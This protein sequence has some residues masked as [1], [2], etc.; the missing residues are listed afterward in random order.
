MNFAI[1]RQDNAELL[2]YLWKIIDLPFIYL[3]DLLY[4]T[5]YELFLFPPEQAAIFINKMLKANLLTEDD[6][7]RIR[8]SSPLNEK[9]TLWQKKRKNKVEEQ[10]KSAEKRRLLTN[11]IEND[12]KSNINLL[13]K[14][15]VEKGTLYRA[16]K[17]TNNA[18]KIRELDTNKGSIKSDVSG[19]KEESY[20]IEINL[21]EKFV[22]HNCHDFETRR[23]REK[24][25]C[26][27][28][29]RLFLL[30]KE[31]DEK[32]AEFFLKEIAENIEE[33]EFSS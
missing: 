32:T 11:N 29:A 19:S 17:I 26:K 31:K 25:F 12:E 27:H 6:N 9:L 30:L 22:K 13:F 23:S 24:Q 7:G 14:I 10:K 15:L 4:K 21:K 2:L 1:P 3:D 16:A 33:W 18:F 20:Y 28:L 8:L 5:S